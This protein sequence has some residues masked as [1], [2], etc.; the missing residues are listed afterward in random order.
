MTRRNLSIRARLTLIFVVVIA[1]VLVAT[2]AVIVV[3]YRHSTTAEASSRITQ[4]I[5]QIQ[6]HDAG[7][8]V[9]SARPLELKTEDHVVVQVTNLAGN[10]VW[11]AS[12]EIYKYPVI[13]HEVASVNAPNGYLVQERAWVKGSDLQ[14]E[15]SLAQAQTIVTGRGLGLIVGFI[16]GQS[17]VRTNHLLLVI[18]SLAIPLLLLIVAIVVWFA[19]GQTLRPVEAIR[20]RVATI[21]AN[22][23]SERVPET[24]G[25]DEVSRMARTLNA[26]LDR[27][28]TSTRIQQEFVSNASHELRSPLTTLLAT[29]DRAS[30]HL[31]DT[32]WEEFT[33]TVRRE[34]RRIDSLVDDLFF[35]ARSDERREEMRREEVDLDDIIDEEARRVRQMTTLRISTSGV[36]PVRVWGDPA[37]IRRLVRNVVDNAL[38][39]A[40]EE[41]AFS[42]RYVGP[43]AEI[44]VH[45]D[46]AGVDVADSARLFQR[47]VRTDAARSRASGGTGLGLPIVAEIAQRHG[48]EARFIVVESGSTMRIRL[49][50]Y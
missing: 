32:D 22:E 38:R 35:L 31:D 46:G 30:N 37:M 9:A 14:G 43:L 24:G 45:D 50:R 17:I 5:A 36:Q 3:F 34:G 41:V 39:F 42:T 29:V 49:R 12:S 2:G 11:A 8:I 40:N 13:S 26:M 44:C 6:V 28:Q 23:L 15:L 21:A 25:D 27:L 10:E 7:G 47:F 33:E 19:V 48:G 16:Y 4:A 1:L 20:R 18:L